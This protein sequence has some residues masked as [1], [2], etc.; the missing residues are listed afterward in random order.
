[1]V[2][3]EVWV[4][5]SKS[6]VGGQKIRHGRIVDLDKT[7]YR[8]IQKTSFKPVFHIKPG[9]FAPKN[10]FSYKT[11]VFVHLETGHPAFHKLCLHPY[12]KSSLPF[13]EYLEV[14]SSKG[15]QTLFGFEPRSIDS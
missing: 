5:N 2:A 1:M 10:W 12:K 8:T 7:G 9:F 14:N 13:S 15:H 3:Y 11:R 6:E 4:I